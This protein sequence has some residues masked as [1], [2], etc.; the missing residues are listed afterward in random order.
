M[1][2]CSFSIFPCTRKTVSSTFHAAAYP[3][4]KYLELA[5]LQRHTSRTKSNLVSIR[6]LLLSNISLAQSGRPPLTHADMRM[7]CANRLFFV[8]VSLVF[9]ISNALNAFKGSIS[10][11][12]FQN[13]AP[14]AF[15]IVWTLYRPSQDNIS[16]LY[17]L[18]DERSFRARVQRE[19]N[20]RLGAVR[21]GAIHANAVVTV[22]TFR[23]I[24]QVP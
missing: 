10:R 14:R 8:S 15:K 13:R 5:F 11:V 19:N 20:I 16:V 9:S 12:R 24:V 6:F 17:E 23:D 22:D 18:L 7:L 1:Q 21:P 4:L 2:F 3:I